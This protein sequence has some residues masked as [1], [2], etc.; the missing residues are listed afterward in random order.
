MP[1]V[2]EVLVKKEVHGQ[3]WTE[4]VPLEQYRVGH[5]KPSQMEK[6]LRAS[7]FQKD[8]FEAREPE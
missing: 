8:N 6:G 3:T 1:K 5:Q 2:I 7:P 4:V